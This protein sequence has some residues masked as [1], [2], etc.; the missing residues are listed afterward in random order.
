MTPGA[1]AYQSRSKSNAT[2]TSSPLVIEAL[3]HS[4]A[5]LVVVDREGRVVDDNEHATRLL[6]TTRGGPLADGLGVSSRELAAL[7]RAPGETLELAGRTQAGDAT[8]L[9]VPVPLPDPT[10]LAVFVHPLTGAADERPRAP[11]GAAGVT[12]REREVLTLLATGRSTVAIAKELGIARTTARN[13]IQAIIGKLDAHSR[14][15]AVA[16]ARDLGLV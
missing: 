9:L 16:K 11:E 12:A 4:P 2:P 15:E 7:F 10:R 3:K 8:L 5:P 14:L 6:A 13:H 1:A